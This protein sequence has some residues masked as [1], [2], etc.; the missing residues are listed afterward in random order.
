MFNAYTVGAATLMLL[1]PAFAC[2]NDELPAQ[3]DKAV[4]SYFSPDAPGAAVIVVKDGQTIFRKSYGMADMARQIRNDAAAQFRL[5]SVTKQFTA[6]AILMLAEEGKLAISDDIRRYLPAFPDKGKLITIEHLLT[7]TS[8]IANYTS[9]PV[10]RQS[11]TLDRT[12]D[13]LID[14]FKQEPLGFDP[15]TKYAY[16]NSG[17]ILL[18]AIIEKVSGMTYA[19]FIEQRIFVPL[20]MLDTAYE[21]H[22][23]SK[24]PRAVGHSTTP[25]GFR[26]A[27]AMSM[28]LPYAAGA[29]VSTVDDLARW[30]AAVTAGKLLKP[31]SWQ[32]AFTRH[33]LADGK[34]TGYGYGWHIDTMQ[35][36]ERY[37]HGGGIPGFSAY[38]MR[39]PRE[40]VFVAVLANNDRL[41][42]STSVVGAR[43]AAI[44]IGKPYPDFTPVA[45]A[46]A[47]FDD[48]VGEYAGDGKTVRTVI[49]DGDKLFMQNGDEPKEEIAAYGAGRFYIPNTLVYMEFARD[50][51]GK[52]AA[53]TVHQHD[54]AETGKR[55][56]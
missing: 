29:I 31:A 55:V 32:R 6:T 14:T 37:A 19:K 2:A 26:L 16:S 4:A 15:G 8:G 45:I 51:A 3:I 56:R 11:L 39:L 12:V 22:G 36:S 35:G 42:M 13:A 38:A 48:Y 44:A 28:T 18:G 41:P 17:Y 43:A 23:T 5:G 7:H 52:I 27:T 30:D 54:R 49:R 46:P 10:V 40:K 21:G 33:T 20:K 47:Q 50:A 24:A 1:Q 25:T 9:L 53:L 34:A